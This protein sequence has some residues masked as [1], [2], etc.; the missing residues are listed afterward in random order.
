M[1]RGAGAIREAQL[2]GAM[3]I[4][5]PAVRVTWV[6]ETTGGTNCPE[7][8]GFIRQEECAGC[9]GILLH[10]PRAQH[11]SGMGCTS[12]AQ[13]ATVLENKRSRESTAVNP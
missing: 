1:E 8:A 6:E 2:T 3:L 10:A 9:P 13:Q 7:F 4:C 11:A 12:C 5:D